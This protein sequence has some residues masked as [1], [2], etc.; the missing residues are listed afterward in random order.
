MAIGV[1]DSLVCAGGRTR[2]AREDVPL[3]QGA[4]LHLSH[5]RLVGQDAQGS[6]Y[7]S[8]DWIRC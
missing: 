3:D 1:N 2:G 7:A 8:H 4:Q 6:I 5:D